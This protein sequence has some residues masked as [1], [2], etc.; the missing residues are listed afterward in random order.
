M[1][2]KTISSKEKKNLAKGNSKYI[3][4]ALCNERSRHIIEL[5]NSISARMEKSEQIL[6][7]QINNVKDDLGDEITENKRSLDGINNKFIAILTG[8]IV[9]IIMLLGNLLLG[10]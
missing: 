2:K 8:I 10:G 1:S 9:T 3:S 4:E 7:K 6:I 5:I